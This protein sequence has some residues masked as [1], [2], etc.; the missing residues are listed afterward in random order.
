MD[1]TPNSKLHLVELALREC[2]AAI[3]KMHSNIHLLP[4]NTHIVCR[5]IAIENKTSVF[6]KT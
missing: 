2:L 4:T 1:L 5:C 3:Q 6:E